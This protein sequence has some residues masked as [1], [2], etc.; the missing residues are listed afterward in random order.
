[1]ARPRAATFDQ[2]RDALLAAAAELFAE[3]G[4]ATASIADLARACGVSKGLL[5][6]YYRDKEHLLFDIADR[7]MD[8]LRAIVEPGAGNGKADP[9]AHLRALIG[10]FMLAYRDSAARHRVLVQDVKYLSPRH[11]N[12]IRAKQKAVVDSL[13]QAIAD[14]A[15]H[16]ADEAARKAML[17]PL[18]M[19]LFGMMN[20]TFT[21]L[22]DDGA[23]S[24]E[25]MAALV[26]DLFLGGVRG[27]RTVRGI[28]DARRNGVPRL[29]LRTRTT[30]PT[31]SYR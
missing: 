22:R 1:M 26:A 15:P 17:K 31:E 19:T 24:Y 20:W 4:Y 25:D 21:W 7:Y 6:H 30:N 16:L 18:T 3:R 28:G 11:R 9:A 14:V 29:R 13:A 2:Q 10:R 27:V 5:Y 23:L 12:R 8:T